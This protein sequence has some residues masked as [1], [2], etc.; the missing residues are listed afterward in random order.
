MAKNQGPDKGGKEEGANRW[1]RNSRTLSFWVLFVLV[2][3]LL[4]Q[5]LTPQQPDAKEL[6]TAGPAQLEQGNIESVTITDGKTGGGELRSPITTERGETRSFTMTLPIRDP[7]A[8]VAELEG[9][10]VARSAGEE[11]RQNWWMMLIGILP[12]ILILG[13]WIFML[14]Q[15]QAGAPRRSSS[16]SPRRRS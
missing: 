2:S 14:R 8:F 16:G 4:V 6:S 12:W 9:A 15:M 11:S 3:V 13:I 5:L 1:T 7:E 10:N